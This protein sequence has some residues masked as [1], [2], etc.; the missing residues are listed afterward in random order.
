LG[1]LNGEKS[2]EA[3]FLKALRTELEAPTRRSRSDTELEPGNFLV[4]EAMEG[5][6]HN[7]YSSTMRNSLKE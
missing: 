5:A 4:S 1:E 2:T 6:E 3:E 7:F